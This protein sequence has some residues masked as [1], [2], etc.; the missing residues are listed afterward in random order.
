M[1]KI[2][3]ALFYLRRPA[4]WAHLRQRAIKPFL[5]D[6][7]SSA[8]REQASRWAGVRA[9]PLAEALTRM[10]LIAGPGD[11]FPALSPQLVHRA[12]RNANR[13]GCVMGGAGH[14]DLIYAAA[15]LSG[16]TAASL[17]W[18]GGGL[19]LLGYAVVLLVLGHLLSW[20]RDVV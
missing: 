8:H 14:I 4:Y 1:A 16:A 20:R 15:K 6:L 2:R 11:G 10:N 19:V 17:E 7:D 9:V 13:S 18:W 12:T 3:S 5:S